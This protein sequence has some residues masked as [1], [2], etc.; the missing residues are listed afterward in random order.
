MCR[1]IRDL[2]ICKFDS[3]K[4]KDLLPSSRLHADL[5]LKNKCSFLYFSQHA[6]IWLGIFNDPSNVKEMVWFNSTTIEYNNFNSP[7]KDILDCMAANKTNSTDLCMYAEVTDNM[8]WKI[9][10]CE[11]KIDFGCEIS[12]F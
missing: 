8:I 10:H 7:T 5:I 3:F 11:E 6:T 9:K 4:Q 2:N 12:R 1:I